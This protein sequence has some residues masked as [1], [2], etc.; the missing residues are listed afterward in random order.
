MLELNSFK[1]LI[2]IFPRGI[3][4]DLF[5]PAKRNM[6]LRQSWGVNDGPETVSKDLIDNPPI[7][8][9]VATFNTSSASATPAKR[10]LVA[11]YAG[12]VSWEKNLKLML[13]AFALLPAHLPAG[14]NCPKLVFAGDGPAWVEAQ[15]FCAD[16][17][18]DSAFEGHRGRDQM[19]ESMASADFFMF[20]SYSE[21]F[22]QVILEAMASGLPV[23]GLDA[24]GTRDLVKRD[25][26]G[27]ILDYPQ[28][29]P[30]KGH[31]NWSTIC[32]FPETEAF[33]SLADDYAQLIAK[34]VIDDDLRTRLTKAAPTIGVAGYT[35]HD[36]LEVC[37]K[38]KLF[39]TSVR[40]LTC[41]SCLEM[42]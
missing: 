30:A 16:K 21:T 17:K 13:H 2:R 4:L 27:L 22:G 18:I 8:P 42:C 23:V 33:A 5:S 39:R 31:P 11:L 40:M 29:N 1:G 28:H 41:V 32:M 20:P 15:K 37:A 6:K 19:A 9:V 26:T 24:D 34:L 38:T 3:N 35:W 7:T 36:A 14:V 25:I 10:P 12:R